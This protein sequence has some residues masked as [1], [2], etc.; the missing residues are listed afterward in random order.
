MV[1]ENGYSCTRTIDDVK[2]DYA[3]IQKMIG[4][5]D[6]QIVAIETK[7]DKLKHEFGKGTAQRLLTLEGMLSNLMYAY[8]GLCSNEKAIRERLEKM[9][10]EKGDT[11]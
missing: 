6:R 11:V 9:E 8:K 1:W 2:Q 10:R 5:Y 3:D 4:E 7:I